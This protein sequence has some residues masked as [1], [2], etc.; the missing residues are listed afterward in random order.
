MDNVT[1]DHD[2][3]VIDQIG[4]SRIDELRVV[5]AELLGHV[6]PD[7]CDQFVITGVERLASLVDLVIDNPAQ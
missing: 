3:Q 1:R 6:G 5:I 4:S 7:V 2:D